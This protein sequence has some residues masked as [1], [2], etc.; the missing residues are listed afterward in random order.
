MDG[1]EDRP[2]LLGA[3]LDQL[4]NVIADRRV[5]P[6]GGLIQAQKA[7][8]GQLNQTDADADAPGLPSRYSPH[9]SRVSHPALSDFLQA[10][11]LNDVVHR[12]LDLFPG[13]EVAGALEHGGEDDG[14]LHRESRLHRDL[15]FHVGHVVLDEV[16]GGRLGVVEDGALHLAD[17]FSKADDVEEHGLAGAAGA[18]DAVELAWL[19]HA[20]DVEERL[21]LSDFRANVVDDEA[22][23]LV[24]RVHAPVARRRAEGVRAAV[25][26]AFF[27][28]E[29]GGG[30][31]V[32]GGVST[33]VR[34]GGAGDESRRTSEGRFALVR[35]CVGLRAESHLLVLL[36]SEAGSL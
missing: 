32:P 2:A 26:E 35:V 14:L 34:A 17:A 1:G 19:D 25:L 15:L 11:L 4:E 36:G 29:E 6:C 12:I 30:K 31:S 10:E 3:A 18:H 20:R 24:H 23:A 16:L 13:E 9:Q 8:P 28:S 21:L 7:G 27:V 33:G 5:Q 22:D